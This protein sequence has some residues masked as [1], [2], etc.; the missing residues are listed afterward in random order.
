[1]SSSTSSGSLFTPLQ[2]TGISQY[3]TDFQSILSRAVSIAQLP[4][5]ALQQQEASITQQES[6]LGTLNGDVSGV[7]SAL[8][9]L[10]Q[11]GS[12]TALTGNSSNTSIVTATSTGA[13]Q[14]GSYTI[15]NVTSLATAASEISKA[16]YATSTSTAVSVS[17]NM[18]LV[19]G[20][21][22]YNIS[23]SSSQNNLQGLADAI[24]GLGAG[25]SA[26]ILTT[27]SGD[28]LSLSANSSGATT[29]Q[30]N[31]VNNGTSTNILTSSNQGTNTNFELDGI[32]VSEPST[33]ISDLIPGLTLNFTGTGSSPVTVNLSTNSASIESALQNLVSSYNSL[34]AANQGQMGQTAGSLAGSNIVYQIGA[35]LTSIVQYQG[36]TSGMS[37]LANLGIEIGETGQM[38]FNQTT[39]SALSS[40]QLAS[41]LSLLGS[42]TTG[43]GGLQQTFAA[44]TDPSTGV[45]TDQQSQWQSEVTDLQAR[46]ASM[47][48]QVNNMEQSLN[49]QLQAADA[50]IAELASQQ[51]LLTA[52]I[53]SLDYTAYGYNT[54]MNTSQTT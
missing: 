30:L 11:L 32:P 53:T 37:N 3:S 51:N 43:I 16:S 27:G 12:G 17:G 26:S 8:V 7:Q 15:S 23:L 39:F 25:V 18:T 52:S 50:S 34:L 46:I 54:N 9:S 14:S 42:S 22:S 10:G 29:L 36:G 19:F 48:T 47:T 2:F 33:T 6:D 24:N 28:Y 20:S 45:I 44:L 49:K 40:S 35:A 31:D 13:A 1:M 38:T 21:N 5:Q 41:A 4:I